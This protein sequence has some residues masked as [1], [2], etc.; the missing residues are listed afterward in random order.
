LNIIERRTEIQLQEL[1]IAE[2]RLI[3]EERE[4]EL[5]IYKL[6]LEIRP[7]ERGEESESRAAEQKKIR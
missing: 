4:R 1:A 7:L 5:E 6:E 3:L 2:R